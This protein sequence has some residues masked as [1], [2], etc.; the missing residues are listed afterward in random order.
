MPRSCRLTRNYSIASLIGI[1]LV[2]TALVLFYR[3]LATESLMEQEGQANSDI[4]RTLANAIWPEYGAFI[5]SAGSLAPAQLRQRE[6]LARLRHELMQKMQGLRVVKVKIYDLEGIVI[7]SSRAGQI[8][9]HKGKS[10]GFRIARNGRVI[11]EIIYRD[12]FSAFE[13]EIYDRNLVASYIPIRRGFDAPVE[14]V[15]EIYSDVTP[16][17]HDIGQT[18]YHIALVVS[19]LMLLLYL[20]LL[21]FV[22]RAEGMIQRYNEEQQ[23]LQQARLDYF[24]RHDELTALHNRSGILHALRSAQQRSLGID[25]ALGVMAIKLLRFKDINDRL[26]HHIGDRLLCAAGRRIVASAPG[27]DAVGR[28]DGDE[29]M[30]LLDNLLSR[31]EVDF[32]A[33]KLQ[34]MFAEPFN[35]DGHRISITPAIGVCLSEG[36]EY[37]VEQLLMNAGSALSVAK[38]SPSRRYVVFDTQMDSEKQERFELEQE[39][40]L[41]VA[42]QQFV[43]HYQPR[44]S[45][46]SG[47]VAGMEAL[48]RWQH[49]ERGLVMPVQFIGLLEESGEIVN[50]G[51]W[52]L[53]EACRQCRR[54]HDEGRELRVAVNI[55]LKQL[56][57]ENF[58]YLVSEA[59]ESAALP[60]QYLELEL[61]ES[62]LAED[63]ARSSELLRQ[64]KRIGVSLA[65]DDFGTGYSSL[66]YLM[67]FPVD[68]IK[69]DR[70]FIRDMIDNREHAALTNA[71]IAMG[72]SLRLAVV[73][74]GIESREQLEFVLQM[75]CDELQG[76]YFSRAVE[77]QACGEV[78]ATIHSMV[79]P[80]NRASDHSPRSQ[81]EDLRPDAAP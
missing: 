47:R 28:T 71:I 7:Y 76:F 48:M 37:T 67:H 62:I 30:M 2:A 77:E 81:T 56:H 49:P 19:A 22:R 66:S 21:L 34:G 72:K 79:L 53:Q 29:F 4:A 58:L 16:L 15:F 1:A 13:E 74:E 64:L 23:S 39:L 26:G 60:P 12:Q 20:F 31:K 44:V 69:I 50:L 25:T 36:E 51:G 38:L 10:N 63:M 32:I 27:G 18:G 5:R 42:Q 40:S 33:T 17:L 80:E 73:A 78:L 35:I 59:L 45:A 8:G 9:D 6:E 70:S 3:H 55:S 14:G 11:S 52:L 46:H 61:T 68:Y 75:G 54:W 43:L 57:A 41:A 65:I 24:E